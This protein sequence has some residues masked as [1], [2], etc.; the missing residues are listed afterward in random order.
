MHEIR[1]GFIEEGIIPS[2]VLLGARPLPD[3]IE[4]PDWS[5]FLPNYENQ[6]IYGVF[7]TMNCVP[8]SRLNITEILCNFHGIKWDGSDRYLAWASGTTKNG[9]TF[10]TVDYHLRDRGCVR[11]YQYPW[12]ETKVRT[13][14][15]YVKEPKILP[16]ADPK[17]MFE[18]FTLGQLRYVSPTIEAMKH[19]LLQG[20]LWVW[21][22][23]HA[24][25]VYG[26][27]DRIRIFDTYAY[28]EGGLGRRSIPLS[29]VW[30]I[31]GAYLA[32]ITPVE[33]TGPLPVDEK[34]SN[35][36][37][38]T[39]EEF[40]DGFKHFLSLTKRGPTEREYNAL[41]YGYWDIETVLDD[42]MFK[43]WSKMT[44]PAAMKQS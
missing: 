15:E 12:D 27:D 6:S 9:N 2:S 18:W 10:S 24:Y 17:E 39:V 44:K 29:D 3:L 31:E 43:I 34:Y 21:G 32:P 38:P 25:V 42:N 1:T 23:G 4:V 33:E 13:F 40:A 37:P 22:Y 20:P 5:A 26:I 8:F 41:R 30:R 16:T 19:T 14:E 35:D 7:D 36:T 28:N 11:E